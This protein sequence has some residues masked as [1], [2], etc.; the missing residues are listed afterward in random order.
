MR[1]RSRRGFLWAAVSL[2]AGFGGWRWLISRP[3]ED[4]IGG[5]FRSGFGFSER[6]WRSVGSSGRLAPTFDRSHA[7]MPRVNGTLGLSPSYENPDVQASWV[8]NLIDAHRKVIQ[9]GMEDIRKLPFTEIV[10]EHK[11]IEGWSYI[12]HWGGTPFA[13]LAQHFW[14]GD[15]APHASIETPDRG[16]Y[17]GLEREA[18]MHP[19]TL[20]CYEMNSQ[21]LTVP[22]GAPLRL[23]VPT[24][25]GIKS[26]KWVGAIRQ[27][28]ARPSD[29]WAERGYDWYS[30]F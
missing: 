27:M 28:E 10:T 3:K 1:M 30:G 16:Y 18:L 7:E 8:I 29:Y 11:C 2:A 13:E 22:H 21:P 19:Q 6:F 4:G 24:K 17:V 25:Y 12:V 23:V 15:I 14:N 9:I 26:I 5:P 20:L